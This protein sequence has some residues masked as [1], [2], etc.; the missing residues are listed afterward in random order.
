M[1]TRREAKLLALLIGVPYNASRGYIVIGMD[2]LVSPAAGLAPSNLVP[3]VGAEA[4]VDGISG[5]EPFVFDGL[6]PVRTRT[7]S[8]HSSSFVTFPNME[9]GR[10]GMA[11]AT[12]ASG[13]CVISPAMSEQQHQQ[14]IAYPD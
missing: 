7:L 4:V 9:A 8:A 2:R 6:R 1:G 3:A 5:S 12:P 11:F 13:E 14:V 10:A